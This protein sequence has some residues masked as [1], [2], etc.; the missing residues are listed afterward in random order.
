M[1]GRIIIY[2]DHAGEYRWV[3]RAPGNNEPMAV[4]SESYVRKADCEQAIT[5]LRR[6]FPLAELVDGS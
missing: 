3:F 6:W 4:A 1:Y 5:Q 2:I